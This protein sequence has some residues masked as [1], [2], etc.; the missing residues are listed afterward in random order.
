M[1]QL[2]FSLCFVLN[3][4]SNR[5][6]TSDGGECVQNSLDAILIWTYL[7][8]CTYSARRGQMTFPFSCKISLLSKSL[9]LGLESNLKA[10]FSVVSPRFCAWLCMC[11]SRQLGFLNMALTLVSL[12]IFPKSE[13]I[14]YLFTNHF[15]RFYPTNSILH[16]YVKNS[17]GFPLSSE[18][19][20]SLKYAKKM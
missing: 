17:T 11:G 6:E 8:I 12:I 4:F 3:W 16:Q 20:H 7:G 5:T 2:R 13:W 9:K 15:F 10:I 19:G 1:L 14:C 18:T